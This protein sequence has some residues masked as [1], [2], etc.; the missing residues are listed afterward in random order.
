VYYS[1][2]LASKKVFLLLPARRKTAG[3]S[4]HFSRWRAAD[5]S[6]QNTDNLITI[7]LEPVINPQNDEKCLGLAG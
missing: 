4:Q 2:I 3:G 5:S 1:G 7:T 6:L